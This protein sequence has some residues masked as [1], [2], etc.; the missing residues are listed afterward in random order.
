MSKPFDSVPYA[1]GPRTSI[2]TDGIALGTIRVGYGGSRNSDI[3]GGQVF[4]ECEKPKP[5]D[6]RIRFVIYHGKSLEC[7]VCAICQYA[8]KP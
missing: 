4:C 1:P 5:K 6:N 8:V 7:R 2:G 3:Q